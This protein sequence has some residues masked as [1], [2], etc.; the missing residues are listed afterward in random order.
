MIDAGRLWAEIEDL[1]LISDAEPPA[2]TRVLFT[3]TDLRARAWLAERLEA[4]GLA[5]RVDAAGNTFARWAGAE[6]DLAPVATGSHI[7]AV[8]ESGRFDGVVGV[9]GAL[10]AVRALRAE[11]FRPRRSIEVVVFTAEEPTRFGLGCVGS[12]LLAGVLAEERLAALRDADGLGFDEVRTAAGLNGPAVAARLA[13]GAYAAFLELHIEQG[14]ELERAGAPIGVVTAIAAPSTLRVTLTGEGGHAG[15]VL[16]PVR[17]DP[18]VAAAEVVAAVDRLARGSG[19]PDTVGT[20][21]VLRVEPG[22]VNS[23][24]RRVS[25]EI[26]V[27]DTDLATRDRVLAAVRDAAREAAAARGVGHADVVVNADDPATC[28]PAVVAAVEA[29]CAEAG[30]AG[31]RM[32]SRA[33]HDAVFMA[34]LCPT[35]MIFVPSRDGVSHRPDEYTS[36]EEVALGA[37][38]LAGA[39]RLLAA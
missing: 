10:E 11:G 18:L 36:P 14:P 23:I 15:A 35:G 33:Y 5:V 9:L 20:T 26:D 24:P 37:R 7:D 8:P 38:V 32:V 30:V 6:P 22:A 28:D 13:D 29:A 2:V 4:A 27:R 1:A 17:H 3:D 39:L 19:R 21:G 34:R 12:R 31:R 16:M 25:M